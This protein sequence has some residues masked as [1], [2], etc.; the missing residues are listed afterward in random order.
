MCVH[1]G[2]VGWPGGGT[3]GSRAAYESRHKTRSARLRSRS[4]NGTLLLLRAPRLGIRR[5]VSPAASN[6]I[7]VF[8]A[9]SIPYLPAACQTAQGCFSRSKPPRARMHPPQPTTRAQ[10][11]AT[12]ITFS[13]EA[14]R[15]AA[16]FPLAFRFSELLASAKP[17][18]SQH[19]ASKRLIFELRRALSLDISR[20]VRLSS[21]A[22]GKT[23][24]IV[25]T[26][27]L[28]SS[29]TLPV[30]PL[31]RMPPL[32]LNPLT[33]SPP[34]HPSA[35]VPAHIHSASDIMENSETLIEFSMKII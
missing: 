29:S 1:R 31:A 26:Q 33:A 7:D 23:A 6:R 10:F 19:R 18:S 2:W 27:P 30:C 5:F 13:F 11:S 14:Q 24:Q 12:S 15:V 35:P 32:P 3:R 20:P 8:R 16:I 4:R 9:L 25:R 28:A 22:A 17:A 21:I 34:P